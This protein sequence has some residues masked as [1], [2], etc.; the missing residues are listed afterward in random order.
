MNVVVVGAGIGGLTAALSLKAAGIDRVQV[1]ESAARIEPL[2]VGINV[3][4]HAVRELT[5]LG[6]ADQLEAIG[7]RTAELAYYDR[8]GP[9]SGPSRVAWT[10]ATTGRST[11]CTVAT[12]SCCS[13]TPSGAARGRCRAVR[14]GCAR[15]GP[16][17]TR[18]LSCGGRRR[19]GARGPI[20][21]SRPTGSTRGARAALPR[22]GPAHLE[23]VGAVAWDLDAPPF[24]TGRSMIMAATATRSSS[25][26][27]W[28]V[29]D[30]GS[31]SSTGSPSEGPRR[32]FDR[33]DWN[34]AVDTASSPGTSNSGGSTGSTC[35]TS[36]RRVERPR[37]PDGRPT[38][39]RR[40]DL[41]R[42]TLLGDAAHPTYPIGSNGSSQ[43]ILDARVLAHCLA[44]HPPRGP[45]VLRGPSPPP[46]RALQQA[47]RRWARR[48][49]CSSRTSAH[50]TASTTSTTCSARRAGVDRRRVQARRWISPDELNDRASWSVR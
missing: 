34:R 27:R 39:A 42:V 6:L 32:H 11:R 23:R 29:A 28:A 31:S 30:D 10:P 18:R 48:S 46:T 25:P 22:R 24:L 20:S 40:L 2:G 38:A 3:L 14:A 15:C 26:I 35:R 36:S 13:S 5:E 45:S 8:H 16:T 1:L 44:S 41:G 43:A 21:W 4:P 49:S 50:R 7:V 37:V 47:N 33:E 12:C 9:G 17:A 19:S